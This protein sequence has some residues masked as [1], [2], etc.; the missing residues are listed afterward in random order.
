MRST[1]GI[2]AHRERMRGRLP[3]L[4]AA[5]ARSLHV[6]A[7]EFGYANVSVRR[8]R[9]VVSQHVPELMYRAAPLHVEGVIGTRVHLYR[10]RRTCLVIAER[11]AVCRRRPVVAA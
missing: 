1:V 6:A 10:D 2:R 8:R 5:A 3:L 11:N 9:R 7:K 4:R